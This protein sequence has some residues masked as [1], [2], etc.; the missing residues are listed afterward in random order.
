MSDVIALSIFAISKTFL[1]QTMYAAGLGY[2]FCEN[3][4][5]KEVEYS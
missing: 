2:T 3:Y 1:F 5:E 4:E